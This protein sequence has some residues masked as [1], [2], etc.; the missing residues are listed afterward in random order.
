MICKCCGNETENI[1]ICDHCGLLVSKEASY[2]LTKEDSL[3]LLQKIKAEYLTPFIN[4]TDEIEKLKRRRKNYE[5]RVGRHSFMRFFW[6]GFIFA[7]ISFFVTLFIVATFDLFA[8]P[9]II[10]PIAVL[11][12]WG[13]VSK[14]QCDKANYRLYEAE[15]A[16]RQN[17]R[18]ISKSIQILEEKA[19]GIEKKLGRMGWLIP[20]RNMNVKDITFIENEIKNDRAKTIPEAIESCNFVNK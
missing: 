15:E 13:I 19:E 7:F 20:N 11:V 5:V 17:D 9:V 2:E 8:L 1:K 18:K 6:P 10:V 3:K 16:N 12:V 4:A 14:K